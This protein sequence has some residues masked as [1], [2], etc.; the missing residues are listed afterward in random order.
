MPPKPKYKRNEIINGALQLVRE[1]GMSALT[2]R[3]L[4]ERLNCSVAP[5][6]SEFK[7]MEELKNEV[8]R[9]AKDIYDGYIK[10]GLKYSL[11]FKGAGL[12]Y[13]EFAQREPNLFRLLFMSESCAGLDNFML[14]DENNAKIVGAL[15]SSWGI[16]IYTARSLHKDIFLYTHGIAVMCATNSCSFTDEEISDRLTFAFTAMLKLFK[17]KK[18]DKS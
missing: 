3:A 10:E 18:N 2:A 14:L 4:S 7:N 15:Q 5:I 1:E 12:K 9:S 6:F 8:M 11:P 16:D 13:I 17:E